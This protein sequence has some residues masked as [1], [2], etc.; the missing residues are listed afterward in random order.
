L[1]RS[2]PERRLDAAQAFLQKELNKFSVCTNLRKRNYY[3]R[4]AQSQQFRN[5][6]VV[7]R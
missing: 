5:H 3:L 7:T 2:V 1:Q 6:A 4:L